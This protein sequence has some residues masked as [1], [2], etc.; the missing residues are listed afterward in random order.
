MRRPV[1][2]VARVTALGLAIVLAL[3]PAPAAH[4]FTVDRHYLMTQQVLETQGVTGA[5][6]TL[7]AY[8]ATLPDVQGCLESCYCV[9]LSWVCSPDSGAVPGLSADHFDNNVFLESIFRVNDRMMA[10]M[11][12]MSTV[13]RQSRA[14]AIALI[15]FGRALHTIQDFYAH[16][17][18]L[19]INLPFVRSNGLASLPLWE[20]QPYTG[21]P[22][23]IDGIFVSDLRTG[24]YLAPI[25]PGQHHHDRIAKDSPFTPEG[26]RTYTG[27]PLSTTYTYYGAVSGDYVNARL[28]GNS[29]LAPRHTIRAFNA[30]FADGT[31]FAY[32]PPWL[33]PNAVAGPPPAAAQAA[34]D[35]FSW[36]NQDSALIAMA[37]DAER[38]ATAATTDTLSPYPPGSIDADGLPLPAPLSVGPPAAAAGLALAA[39]RPNPF[40]DGTALRFHVPVAGRVEL[41]IFDPGGRRIA[42]PYSGDAGPGWVE[43][44]WDGRDDA[45][46]TV[47]PG[48]YRVRLTGPGPTVSRPIA[49]LW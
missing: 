46:R 40:R 7:I 9:Y 35:F 3:T 41:A 37:A 15:Q 32:W 10:M 49:R 1:P 12:G 29:G 43:A 26:S 30:L 22:W 38:L 8:G 5:A 31:V 16:S 23:P 21:T 39:P 6:R 33:G 47:R 45:G 42:T 36:V 13:N 14:S 19:E 17:S 48:V 28:F 24:Y 44:R 34:P 25:P 2:S 4:A 11:N 27:F 20:G 18:Y